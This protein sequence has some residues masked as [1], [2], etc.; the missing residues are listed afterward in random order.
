MKII[1]LIIRSHCPIEYETYL[2]K[3][4][5]KMQLNQFKKSIPI[6]NSGF[7]PKNRTAFLLFFTSNKFQYFYIPLKI[8]KCNAIICVQCKYTIH[9]CMCIFESVYFLDF[10]NTCIT[11][12]SNKCV[13]CVNPKVNTWVKFKLNI[14]SI[15][16]FV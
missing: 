9:L 6:Y 3:K 7:C 14:F 10:Y 15:L 5:F 4:S 12:L 8:C 2:N 11:K 1:D 13:V 16:K